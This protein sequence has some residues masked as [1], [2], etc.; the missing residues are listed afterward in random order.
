M[1]SWVKCVRELSI[2]YLSNSLCLKLFQDIKLKMLNDSLKQ[3]N[4]NILWTAQRTT[5]EKNVSQANLYPASIYI[6]PVPLS[7]S[8]TWGRLFN[9]ASISPWMEFPPL[10]GLSLLLYVNVLI[11]DFL[12][13][14]IHTAWQILNNT[15]RVNMWEKNN[16]NIKLKENL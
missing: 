12:V 8:I 6:P 3:S 15:V 2:L 1:G 5:G 11:Y 13:L 10:G 7:C 4:N 9:W 14:S 16:R